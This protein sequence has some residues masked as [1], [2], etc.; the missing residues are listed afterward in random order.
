[1]E[2][3]NTIERMVEEYKEKRSFY[4]SFA[5]TI[6]N[7]LG[8]LLTAEHL[9]VH[10]I[11]CR[12]KDTDSFRRKLE[13]EP[14]K[15]SELDDL[16]DLAGVRVITYFPD[17]VDRVS[18]VVQKE[19]D[20]DPKNSIDKRELLDPDRFG[21]LSLHYIVKLSGKRVALPE[22]KQFH[23]Y[24]LEIQIRSILQHTWAEIEH[25]LGYKSVQAIPRGIRRRFSR[26][27]GLL[28]IADTEFAAIRDEILLYERNVTQQIGIA[29][30]QVTIDQVSLKAFV[31]RDNTVAYLHAFVVSNSGNITS[32]LS[33]D[34]IGKLPA[35]LNFIGI[36]TI[37]HLKEK[38]DANRE[39][40]AQF[41]LCNYGGSFKGIGHHFGAPLSS[42]CGLLVIESGGRHGLERFFT[43]FRGKNSIEMMYI[44]KYVECYKT[45]TKVDG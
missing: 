37:G 28:E 41:M 19:F 4:D 18:E 36:E 40:L 7:L 2:N 5:T 10:S 31:K 9:H 3:E 20:I 8:K 12:A 26:L 16:T 44:D 6:A 34:F 43:T 29:P 25:D 21:Y 17:E 23:S 42:L 15:Y 14:M 27:A 1:M 33:D 24:Q 38:L 45:V 11:T 32:E 13:K 22:Y 35:E 30:L 39:R